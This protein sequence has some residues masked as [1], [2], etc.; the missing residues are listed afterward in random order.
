MYMQV[1]ILV[2]THLHR[3]D[4]SAEGKYGGTVFDCRLVIKG[5]LS[6]QQQDGYLE[7]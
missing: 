3:G 7:K 4:H 1:H 6:V 5:S 2:S